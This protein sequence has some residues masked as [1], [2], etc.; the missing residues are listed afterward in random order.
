M[1]GQDPPRLG[2]EVVVG[3]IAVVVIAV[4]IAWALLH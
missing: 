2:L 1:G 4:L 3:A